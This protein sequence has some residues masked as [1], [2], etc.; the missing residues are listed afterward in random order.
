MR[1]LLI[2]FLTLFPLSVL[3]A[4]V[5]DTSELDK[6][7]KGEYS[8][9]EGQLQ[10]LFTDTTTKAFALQE[11]Q[12]L[13]VQVKSTDFNN[14]LM[15]IQSH[16]EKKHILSIQNDEAVHLVLNEESYVNSG[17]DLVTN[18]RTIMEGN[19]DPETVSDF[20]FKDEYQAVMIHLKETA[21]MQDANRI[22]NQHPDI[23]IR[24]LLEPRRAAVVQTNP[25]DEDDM[26]SLLESRPYV[27]S[28]AYMGVLK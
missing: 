17:E 7:Q 2:F 20:K 19:I 22:I 8:I 6:L 23:K 25:D 9:A 10:V 3:H 13:G 5:I 18:E 12:K 28:V 26:I 21:T 11:M 14:I 24:V 1:A 16:P 4:Q 15:L 27:M